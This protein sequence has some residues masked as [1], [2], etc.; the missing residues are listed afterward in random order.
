MNKCLIN[1][2]EI[3][4]LYKG[5]LV[6]LSD[7]N[8]YRLTDCEFS[9]GGRLVIG[10]EESPE[11]RFKEERKEEIKYSKGEVLLRDDEFSFSETKLN[12]ISIMMMPSQKEKPYLK[13]EDTLT[14]LFPASF[15]FVC[16]L[17]G[18]LFKKL[19]GV[20]RQINSGTCE[21]RHYEAMTRIAKVEGKLLRKQA[22]DGGK[23]IKQ[24]FDENKNKNSDVQN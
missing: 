19:A 23:K 24:K 18:V 15:L 13:S 8:F 1:N 9:P 4:I 5:G 2:G 21:M 14:D 20:N 7:G 10:V 16:G 17:I 11:R 12:P 22:I 6:K 3:G